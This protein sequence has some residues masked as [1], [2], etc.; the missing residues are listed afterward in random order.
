MPTLTDRIVTLITNEICE[1]RNIKIDT[2]NITPTGVDWTFTDGTRIGTSKMAMMT[3]AFHDEGVVENLIK[4]FINTEL[5][6]QLT[7]LNKK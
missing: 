5:D 4:V 2:M 7:K 3:T 6:D 1:S